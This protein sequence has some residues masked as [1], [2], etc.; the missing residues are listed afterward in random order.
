MLDGIVSLVRSG[1][2]IQ[3]VTSQHLSDADIEA[4]KIGYSKRHEVIENSF[5]ISFEEEVEKLDDS[6]LEI[7]SE[8][9]ARGIMDVKVA[10]TKG[11]G[12]YHDKFGI[13]EDTA[14]IA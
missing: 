8:L 13:I 3:L 6:N 12:I 10:V 2:K 5:L 7:L 9:V 4:I 11:L 1:G 14:G